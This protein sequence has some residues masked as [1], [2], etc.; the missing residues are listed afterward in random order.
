VLCGGGG[1]RMRR[2]ATV[3]A[4]VAAV[5][6]RLGAPVR[7]LASTAAATAATIRHPHHQQS[8]PRIIDPGVRWRGS[9][10]VQTPQEGHTSPGGFGGG[11]RRGEGG[12]KISAAA[13]APARVSLPDVYLSGGRHGAPAVGNGALVADELRA[14]GEMLLLE[15]V[16]LEVGAYPAS[17]VHPALYTGSLFSGN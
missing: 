5:A 2:A 12:G 11:G 6:A 3:P 16:R 17:L 1:G 10:V 14:G 13:A 7:L 4:V 8:Q 15:V 9:L